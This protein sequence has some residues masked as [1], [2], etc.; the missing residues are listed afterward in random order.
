MVA[1]SCPNDL[2]VP[3]GDVRLGASAYAPLIGMACAGAC[4][5]NASRWSPVALTHGDRR[6]SSP[7][8]CREL[9]QLT[10]GCEVWTHAARGDTRCLLMGAL[11]ADEPRPAPLDEPAGEAGFTSGAR[12]CGSRLGVRF[13]TGL[14][15]DSA[16]VDAARR[17]V[18]LAASGRPCHAAGFV[19]G[20]G[21]RSCA[22]SERTAVV[23]Q[24]SVLARGVDEGWWPPAVARA[25]LARRLPAGASP[26]ARQCQEWCQQ[27]GKES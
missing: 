15:A 25:D 11:G 5:A 17:A 8:A 21:L 18:A 26:T 3:Y 6:V 14:L 12:A 7:L 19:Y 13:P 1:A 4:Y 24:A 27:S 20:G 2:L 22:R 23:A 16:A 9:C 10:P